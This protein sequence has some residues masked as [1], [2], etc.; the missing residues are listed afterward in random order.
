MS[1]GPGAREAGLLTSLRGLMSTGLTLAETR[2]ALLGNELEE[3]KVRI[4]EGLVLAVAGLFVLGVG[5]ALFCALVLL[6]FWEGYR[7][8]ALALLT[9]AFV[10]GGGWLLA[11]AR[12]RLRSEGGPFRASLEELR[13]DRATVGGDAVR[14]G[15]AIPDPGPAGGSAASAP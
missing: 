7:L 11:T 5:V 3:Q 15:H 10:A 14:D 4:V 9:V 8:P 1:E 12:R 2:L 6:L 13:Q